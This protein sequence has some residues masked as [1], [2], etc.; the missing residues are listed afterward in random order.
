MNIKTVAL[1]ADGSSDH[2]VLGPLVTL[3]LDEH[4]PVPYRLIH[5]DG[6]ERGADLQTRIRSAVNRFP[7]DLLLIHRD[8]ESAPVTAREQEID[9]AAKR[10]AAPPY[11]KVI[12]V[13]MTEAWLLADE[14]AI[15]AAVGNPADTRPLGLPSLRD[16]E[17]SQ[18]KDVL[19]RAIRNASGLGARRR[20]GLLP[21]QFRHRVAE[22]I[23]SLE[24]IRRLA[25]FRHFEAA[26]VANVQDWRSV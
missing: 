1:L 9:T 11:V 7:C 5:A 14:A 26:L 18:A 16:I 24:P 8:A 15:R 20:R 21:Q 25:S 19:L 23:E 22:T 3:A 6:A 2:H 17:N 13:R 10:A 12:P 4:S